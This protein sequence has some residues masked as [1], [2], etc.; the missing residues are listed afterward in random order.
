MFP[1]GCESDFISVYLNNCSDFDVKA[2]SSFSIV[3]SSKKLQDTFYL[4]PSKFTHGDHLNNSLGGEVVK[5]DKL[6]NNSSTLLSEG[7]LTI[8]CKLE[9]YGKDK[10]F[11]G[12]NQFSNETA[13]NEECQRQ[14]TDHLDK[15]LAEKNLYD[16][17]VTCD[18]EVFPCHQA[19]LSARSPVFLAMFQSDMVDFD[20]FNEKN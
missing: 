12:S 7:N 1:Q 3:D 13:I 4:E 8:L 10:V 5:L 19:I 2:K 6:E 11:S 9:V 14:V 18:E 20:S 17:E 15:L 16:L